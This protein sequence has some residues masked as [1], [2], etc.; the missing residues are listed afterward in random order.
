[1]KQ[2]YTIWPRGQERATSFP[3]VK[4]MCGG[5]MQLRRRGIAWPATG[6]MLRTRHFWMQG[7]VGG[8][9]YSSARTTQAGTGVTQR[10]GK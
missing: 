4:T 9:T 6:S 7:A 1:M 5:R 3:V 2:K 10:A 8:V